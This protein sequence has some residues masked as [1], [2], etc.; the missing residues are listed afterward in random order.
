MLTIGSLALSFHIEL[1]RNPRDLDI[2]GTYD[3]CIKFMKEF[4]EIHPIVQMYPASK[5]KK[6]IAKYSNGDI[7]E[8]EIAWKG[9]STE[10]FIELMEAEGYPEYAS[11]NG[12]YALKMSHRFLRNSPHF[13]KTRADI[14]EMRD[15]GAYLT[16]D[17]IGWLELREKE[18]YDYDHPKLNVSKEE[19]FTDDIDYVYDH[20]S[21]HES[22]KHYD[23]PVYQYFIIGEVECSEE[24][25]N[26]L[27]HIV[28]LTAVLEESYTLAIERSLVPHPGVKTPREAFNIA[29]MKVCTSITSGWFRDFAWEHYDEVVKLYNDNYYNKFLTGLHNGTVIKN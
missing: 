28:K 19:F 18:T 24:K 23:K 2:M 5:G 21:I 26:E 14:K 3:E 7:I 22:V 16:K 8:A 4:G 20:D 25:F 1:D 13:H 11:L 6:M 15:A 9:S 10:K 12:L 27:E 29:L 17:L